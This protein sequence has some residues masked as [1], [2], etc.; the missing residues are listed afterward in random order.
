ME[1]NIKNLLTFVPAKDFD[2]SRAFYK[3]L[4]FTETFY[5]EDLSK[6]KT[7]NFHFY[8]QNYYVKTWAENFMMFLEVEGVN[9]WWEFIKSLNLDKKY[10]NIKL[11]PPSVKDWGTEFLFHDPSGVLWHIGKYSK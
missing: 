6:F 11:F 4:G 10:P 1:N 8:L 5:S 3:E 9:Q 7:G 2:L